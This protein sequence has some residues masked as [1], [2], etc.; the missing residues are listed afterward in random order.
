MKM[1][2]K[3]LYVRVLKEIKYFYKTSNLILYVINSPFLIGFFTSL[4]RC[5]PKRFNYEFLI[6]INDYL[7]IVNEEMSYKILLFNINSNEKLDKVKKLIKDY[8]L[9]WKSGLPIIKD[10]DEKFIA[11]NKKNLYLTIN[12][13]GLVTWSDGL[14]WYYDNKEK[15]K[16]KYEIITLD[17]C[18]Q[19]LKKIRDKIN[20]NL[21]KLLKDNYKHYLSYYKDTVI[22]D[23]KKYYN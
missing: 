1:T 5:L 15:F 14:D 19:R 6:S 22:Y 3:S 20:S 21:D 17:E 2:A 4:N 9:I 12:N 8:G 11:C 23:Y 7:N 13:Y 10:L 16:Y 18:E